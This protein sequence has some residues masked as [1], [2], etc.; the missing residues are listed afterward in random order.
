MVCFTLCNYFTIVK[1]NVKFH[2]K[3]LTA[4]KIK[5]VYPSLMRGLVPYQQ[6]IIRWRSTNFRL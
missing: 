6:A 4:S 3:P 2:K 1:Y 5:G